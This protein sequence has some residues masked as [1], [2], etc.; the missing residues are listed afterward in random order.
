MTWEEIESAIKE[1][2]HTDQAAIWASGTDKGK[3][4][5]GNYSKAAIDKRTREIYDDLDNDL[6]EI[7]IEKKGR[8]TYEAIKEDFMSVKSEAEKVSEL[9]QQIESLK[10]KGADET[11]T[12]QLEALTNESNNYKN[13]IEQLKREAVDYKKKTY[14]ESALSGLEFDEKHDPKLLNLMREKVLTDLLTNSE[15]EGDNIRLKRLDNGEI[16]LNTEHK[17]ISAQ[18]AVKELLSDYLKADA[19]KGLGGKPEGGQG[20][21]SL[22]VPVDMSNLKKG[23]VQGA[24]SALESSYINSGKQAELNS[25]A[26]TIDFKIL[27]NKLQEL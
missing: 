2:G 16:W 9:M 11:L 27:T 24:Y 4:L 22:S 21:S 5:L 15:V 13:E 26:F 3:E 19:P 12:A 23:D 14:F 7:G 17:P 8:K 18:N 6:R 20:A 10:N 25:D 1:H